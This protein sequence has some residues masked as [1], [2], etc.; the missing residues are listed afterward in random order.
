[1]MTQR[2][3]PNKVSLFLADAIFMM[4]LV[5]EPAH[6][7]YF[8]SY[9]RAIAAFW[10]Q[11]RMLRN[12]YYYFKNLWAILTCSRARANPSSVLSVVNAINAA[13]IVFSVCVIIA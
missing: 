2:Q 4:H 6:L 11:L 12:P 1:M 9:F 3:L 5:P 13:P 10:Q 8:F 7:K